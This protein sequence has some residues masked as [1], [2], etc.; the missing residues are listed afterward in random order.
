[1]GPTKRIFA[2]NGS[3]RFLFLLTCICSTTY[4]SVFDCSHLLLDAQIAY[5]DFINHPHPTFV[6]SA[7]DTDALH[8]LGK[9]YYPS[10]YVSAKSD[11]SM[12]YPWLTSIALGPAFY[13]QKS[14]FTG[15]VWELQL[16]EFNNY[17]YA[18]TSQDY[19]LLFESNFYFPAQWLYPF[20]SLGLGFSTIDLEY[21]DVAR[22]GI[23]VNTE[24]HVAKHNFNLAY[25]AGIGV[26]Y[27]INSELFFDIRYSYI[28]LGQAETG[29]ST[30]IR[31][32]QSI[33]T[34]L[35]SHNLFLG[36]TFKV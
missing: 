17:R 13:Y 12:N 16:P 9:N 3:N 8:N 21:R 5:T 30:S 11:F 1:M 31:L 27:P 22:P 15:D 36:F 25:Q 20:L 6:I 14:R 23:P 10:I 28:H 32:Q 35:N 33:R 2:V 18:M 29:R 24:L 19:T 4:A 34:A 7:Y 26:Y